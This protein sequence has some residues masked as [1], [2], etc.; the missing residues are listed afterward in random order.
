M[1][2]FIQIRIEPHFGCMPFPVFYQAINRPP[3]GAAALVLIRH[4]LSGNAIAQ[5]PA[6]GVL[7]GR[8]IDGI[9]RLQSCQMV[10][11]IEHVL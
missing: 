3:K 10:M 7:V 2:K 11:K 8:G 6:L 5:I 9:E 4:N 1:R